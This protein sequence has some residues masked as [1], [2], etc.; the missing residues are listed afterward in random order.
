MPASIA[1]AMPPSSSTSW[2]WPQACS[3]APASAARH[4]TSR[5]TDRRCAS[6]RFP[7]AARAGCCARCGR[8]NRSAAPAPR[9][10]RWCAATGCGPASPPSPRS[11]VRTDVVEHVLRGE[12]PARGLAVRAQRQ[13]A[14]ILRLELLHQLRPEQARGAQLRHLHEEVHA[15]RPEERQ[16]RREAVDV[17]PGLRCRRGHIRR[18]RRAC[19]RARGPASR[20]PP[21]CDS[22]RSR[23]S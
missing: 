17:E 5:P 22:R 11:Q 9:R 13:R 3:R 21:A 7:A 16:A 19:R 23:S 4:R 14:R 10:A 18:R 8:R 1:F 2:M 6:C 12:R 15:D 20:R